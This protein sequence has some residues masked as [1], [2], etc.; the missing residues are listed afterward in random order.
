MTKLTY[1]GMWP[2]TK[3]TINFY[4]DLIKFPCQILSNSWEG[5]KMVFR[6]PSELF[7]CSNGS[8][9]IR[10]GKQPYFHD[11][12]HQQRTY[13]LKRYLCT[14]VLNLQLRFVSF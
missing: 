7:T 1:P 12:A 10:A 9:K 4:Y 3:T 8:A 5:T 2:F 13:F 14:V 6:F 11:F